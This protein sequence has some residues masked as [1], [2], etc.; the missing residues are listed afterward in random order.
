MAIDLA[1]FKLAF[2]RWE[3]C[4]DSVLEFWADLSECLICLPVG[5]KAIAKRLPFLTLDH[6]LLVNGVQC[7][8][9]PTLE[10][11]GELCECDDSFV[12]S[13][14]ARGGLVSSANIDGL[15]VSFDNTGLNTQ[16]A[17][18]TGTSGLHAWLSTTA[19]GRMVSIILRRSAGGPLMA[20]G[21]TRQLGHFEEPR[22]MGHLRGG[23]GH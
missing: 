23:L 18:M 9:E 13:I 17:T 3:H 21:N 14:L 12:R 16:I 11:D 7:E 5:C 8:A 15:S 19:S 22:V 4:D 2:T 1:A 10:D 20:I 6:L